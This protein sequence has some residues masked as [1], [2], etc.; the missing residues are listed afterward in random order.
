MSSWNHHQ[1]QALSLLATTP[2][3]KGLAE[4]VTTQNDSLMA[5]VLLG[6]FAPTPSGTL[7]GDGIG[8]MPERQEIRGPLSTPTH[9]STS[10][11]NHSSRRLW[12]NLRPERQ[13]VQDLS[14]E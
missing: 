11:L 10:P 7:D 4:D 3:V 14:Q 8:R 9:G 5:K 13:Q 2:K 12:G 6:T 1:G